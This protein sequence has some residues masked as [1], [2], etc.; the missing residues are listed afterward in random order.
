MNP[1]RVLILDTETTNTRDDPNAICIEVGVI[2]FD[3]RIGCALESYA[4]LIRADRN[5][6]EHING[7]SV[8][9][10][11]TA[12][13]AELVWKRV[14]KISTKADAVC[15]H[16]AEFDRHF[17]PVTIA[18]HI[19]WVCTCEDFEWPK[20]R[21][22]GDLI[23]TAIAHGLGVSHA[24]RVM[25]DCDLISRLFTRLHETEHD[26]VALMNRAL[27]PKKMYA[28]QVSYDDKQ[29]AKDAGFR[30]DDKKRLWL[31]KMVPDN[32]KTLPFKVVEVAA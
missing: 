21:P 18:S 14:D 31:R 20:G 28:A 5:E 12:S 2:L 13:K 4:S 26:L 7:I 16:G 25:S 32:T 27:R 8:E 29:K 11:K 19:P 17:V 3:L 24:H 10:L 22:G 15:A 6:A 30:W 9:A 23:R 1:R